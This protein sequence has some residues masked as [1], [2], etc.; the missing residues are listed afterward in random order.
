[1]IP[2]FFG[3]HLFVEKSKLKFNFRLSVYLLAVLTLAILYYSLPS[4]DL[5]R[6]TS[7][8]YIRYAIYNACIHLVIAFIPFLSSSGTRGFWN[9]NITLFIRILTSLFYSTVLFIGISLA[10]LAL[11]LLFDIDFDEKI[12]LQIF[13]MIIGLFNTWFFLAGVPEDIDQMEEINEFPKP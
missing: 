12:Y 13:I 8:P 11:H 1:G 7:L 4:Q 2:L 5:T 10:L 6:N 3:A 9:Y